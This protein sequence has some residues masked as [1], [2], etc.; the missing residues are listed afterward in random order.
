MTARTE[1]KTYN[2]QIDIVLN[3]CVLFNLAYVQIPAGAILQLVTTQKQELVYISVIVNLPYAMLISNFS[4]SN[5]KSFLGISNKNL[6][7]IVLCESI[8]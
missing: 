7:D 4:N 3:K 8:A 1:I 2:F 5:L 6:M